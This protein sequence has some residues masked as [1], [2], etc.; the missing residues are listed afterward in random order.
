M[1]GLLSDGVTIGITILATKGIPVMVGDSAGWFLTVN[2]DHNS[3]MS[4][5]EAVRSK[6]N[7]LLPP[8]QRDSYG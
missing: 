3:K 5:A 6:V 4:A 8:T 2:T 1:Q 7:F